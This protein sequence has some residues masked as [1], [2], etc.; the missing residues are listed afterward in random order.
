MDRFIDWVKQL[1][2][3][4]WLFYPGVWMAL[5]LLTNALKWLDGSQ[6]PGTV[7][8]LLALGALLAIYFPAMMHYLKE[9]A[10]AALRTFRP[11]LSVNESEYARLRYQLTTL[12]ARGTWVASGIGIT[13]AVLYWLL[14]PTA[15]PDYIS[16]LPVL[17]LDSGSFIC[18]LAA[19]GALVYHTIHQLRTVS[20]IHAFIPRVMH[21]PGAGDAVMCSR[22]APLDYGDRCLGWGWSGWCGWRPWLGT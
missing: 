16:S 10:S 5:F 13:M 21:K 20:R 7:E 8:P 18:A 9:A 17:V 11:V 22:R 12:P 2:G 14:R 4:S 15:M 3:P 19:L 1:P 6:S